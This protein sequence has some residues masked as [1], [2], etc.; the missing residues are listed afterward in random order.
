VTISSLLSKRNK[1]TSV[2]ADFQNTPEHAGKLVVHRVVAAKEN[3]KVRIIDPYDPENSETFDLHSDEDRNNLIAWIISVH[4]EKNMSPKDRTTLE[5][6]AKN[7][8]ERSFENNLMFG[9]IDAR[10][11]GIRQNHSIPH[12]ME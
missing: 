5:A 2:V 11:V 6:N 1:S 12:N 8:L 9:L 3:D 4:V 7:V 10:I